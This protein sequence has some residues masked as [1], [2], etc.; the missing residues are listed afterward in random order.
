MCTPSPYDQKTN[1]HTF[2]FRY[3][4]FAVPAPQN[5]VPLKKKLEFLSK[6]RRN[7]NQ[8]RNI[9]NLR[10]ERTLRLYSLLTSP[11]PII[12]VCEREGGVRIRL[13]TVHTKNTLNYKAYFTE[14]IKGIIILLVKMVSLDT[15]TVRNRRRLIVTYPIDPFHDLSSKFIFFSQKF[16]IGKK[17]RSRF[18]Q[19][20][21]EP[22]IGVQIKHHKIL[23]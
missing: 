21:D 4:Y 17:D 2:S 15:C 1:V 7:G 5:I 13:S 16:E 9:C 22:S 3:E 23:L 11:L 12:Q 8:R 18:R 20:L 6:I 19:K 10:K 14:G